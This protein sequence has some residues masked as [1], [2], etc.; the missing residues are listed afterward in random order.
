LFAGSVVW[1]PGAAVIAP[2]WAK[3]VK[4]TR[5]WSK[6]RAIEHRH[7]ILGLTDETDHFQ[8]TFQKSSKSAARCIFAK[9]FV[10]F[11]VPGPF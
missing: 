1:V 2:A 9:K 3:S 10:R 5:D 6:R 4:M 7:F 11:G 8:P